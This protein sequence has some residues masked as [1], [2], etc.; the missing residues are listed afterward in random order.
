MNTGIRGFLAAA[1]IALVVA[2]SAQAQPQPQEPT[3]VTTPRTLPRGWFGV[4]ISDN[5]IFDDS[6][7]AFFDGYPVVNVVERGSPADKA[8][9]RVGDVLVTFNSLDMKG[10]ALQLRNM[11]QP[12]TPFVLRL[13]RH[14]SVRDVRGTIGVRPEG[15]VPTTEV[16]ISGTE[17][18]QP[19]G[20]QRIRIIRTPGAR[21]PP[22]VPAKLPPVLLS[23]FSYGGG[24][25][26]F[27]GAE[28]TALNE[29]LSEVLG[30]RDEG[31]FVT[32]VL[33]GSPART[34][35]LRGGDVVL[36][37]DSIKLDDPVALVRA[38]TEATDRSIRLQILRKRKPQT[39]VLRW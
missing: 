30:V 32:T 16:A 13:R 34:S 9:V 26:P 27:A 4:T 37:A 12:G 11:M 22:P 25:Y 3:Q 18:R 33:D 31:I 19:V 10:A 38:V 23:A 36:M 14:S 1:V 35:G 2:D 20:S 8:G 21:V 5:G 28:F 29:D 7:R 24:V 39:I 17:Q 15:W 6:G